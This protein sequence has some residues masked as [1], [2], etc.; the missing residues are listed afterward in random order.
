MIIGAPPHLTTVACLACPGRMLLML[1]PAV[2]RPDSLLSGC[3]LARP[4]CSCGDATVTC[5]R[6]VLAAGAAGA[7]AAVDDLKML[8]GGWRAHRVGSSASSRQ[9]RQDMPP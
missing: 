8:C 3:N 5:R 2:R 1:R 9:D 4:L 6:A 7:A